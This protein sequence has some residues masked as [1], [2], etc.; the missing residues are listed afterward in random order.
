MAVRVT[1]TRESSYLIKKNTQNAEFSVVTPEQSKHIRPVDTAI[2][3]MILQRHLE[4]NIYLNELFRTNKPEQHNKTFWFPTPENPGKSRDH[5][6]IETRILK[7]LF[8]LR[9]KEELNPKESTESRSKSLKRFEW[10]DT[11]LTETEKQAIEDIL[12]K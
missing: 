1:K 3:S 10:T 9:G 11:L 12:L 4:L 8:E 5:T 2:L 7:E 6:P